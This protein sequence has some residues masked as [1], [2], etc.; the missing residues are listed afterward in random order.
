MLSL[1]AQVTRTP[2]RKPSRCP[3][4]KIVTYDLTYTF[5]KS[6]VS[7]ILRIS[8]KYYTFAFRIAKNIYVCS[9]SC[10]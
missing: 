4:G 9:K 2:V 1:V 7:N 10:I 3:M 6:D 8:L 5:K